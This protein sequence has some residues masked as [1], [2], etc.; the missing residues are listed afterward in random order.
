[1]S[2]NV[3]TPASQASQIFAFPEILYL[4][5]FPRAYRFDAKKG[6]L[7]FNGEKDITKK[8]EAFTLIPLAYRIFT[9]EIMGFSRRLWAELFFLNEAG[10]MCSLLF[11]HYSV[12]QLLR[13]VGEL[14]YE[15]ANLTNVRLS[16]T[17]EPRQNGY[18]SY[19]VA[20]FR[21][22][23]LPEEE[24]TQLAILVDSLPPLYRQDTLTGDVS[25]NI[26]V[27]YAPPTSDTPDAL[28]EVPASTADL[29]LVEG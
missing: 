13:T 2:K 27:N 1:M 5:G 24:R 14:F 18:G 3:L 4:P 25:T 9:D 28:A 20:S 29:L 21:C 15:K 11:H 12:E 7:N 6:V 10:Q 22:E 17:P 16:I 19:Y 26:S 8:G 23:P